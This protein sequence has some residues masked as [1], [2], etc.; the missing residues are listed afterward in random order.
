MFL[1]FLA[2]FG[3]IAIKMVVS[4]YQTLLNESNAI[5]TDITACDNLT[6]KDNSLQI[7]KMYCVFKLSCSF[8][9]DR[10]KDGG[11][12]LSNTAE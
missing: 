8:W 1:N 6:S 4:N 5:E 2:A 9:C 3:A 12:K 10:N 11:L 7:V